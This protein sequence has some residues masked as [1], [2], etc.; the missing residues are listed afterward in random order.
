M[1]DVNDK[2]IDNIDDVVPAFKDNVATTNI[3]KKIPK[4]KTEKSK[5]SLK[6]KKN[7]TKSYTTPRKKRKPSKKKEDV[8]I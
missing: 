4:K 1:K 2:I 6:A 3:C 8:L 5:T 7:T